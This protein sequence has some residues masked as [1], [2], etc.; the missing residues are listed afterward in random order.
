MIW[1]NLR[2]GLYT[3]VIFRLLVV[4]PTDADSCAFQCSVLFGLMFPNL[5][6]SE[7][8]ADR[9]PLVVRFLNKVGCL[10]SLFLQ[11][12]YLRACCLLRR[13]N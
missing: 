7:N 5:Y 11:K 12:L 6:L 8:L 1:S 2:L 3:F 13:L 9:S 10:G 4:I